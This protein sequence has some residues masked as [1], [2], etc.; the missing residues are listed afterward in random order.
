MADF[1]LL[2]G[3][4]AHEVVD[5]VLALLGGG[6]GAEA[7]LAH[8][9]GALLLADA[10]EL[11]DALV[12]GGQAGDLGD[13]GLDGA[14]ALVGQAEARLAGDGLGAGRRAEAAV[15]AGDD[16][17]AGH[18]GLLGLALDG[19]HRGWSWEDEVWGSTHRFR[20]RE[21][22]RVKPNVALLM[23]ATDETGSIIVLHAFKERDVFCC[24]GEMSHRYH[25]CA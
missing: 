7:L 16:A 4:S 20:G 1:L 5:A 17:V 6:E 10:E 11:D 21:R 3:G 22:K 19:G 12:Q 23:V 13:D 18:G 15:E 14:G 24:C 2:L 8:L 9:D 25:F